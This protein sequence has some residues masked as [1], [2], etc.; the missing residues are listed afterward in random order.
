VA[1]HPGATA[2]IQKVIMSRRIGI[3]RPERE[4]AGAL[5]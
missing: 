5:A 4:R 2:D 3:G 1:V